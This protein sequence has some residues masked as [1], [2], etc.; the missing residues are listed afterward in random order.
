[1]V[2]DYGQEWDKMISYVV[3]AYNTSVHDATKKSPFELIY[4][5]VPQLPINCPTKIGGH[6]S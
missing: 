2:N 1:M 5:R 6:G 3:F 4:G